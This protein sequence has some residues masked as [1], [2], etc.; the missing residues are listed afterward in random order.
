MTHVA[1]FPHTHTHTYKL[2]LQ[3]QLW[4]HLQYW[5]PQREKLILQWPFGERLLPDWAFSL[6]YC[7]S[8]IHC[9][10]TKQQSLYFLFRLA[11]A[12]PVNVNCHVT[13][14]NSPYF[15]NGAE[16]FCNLRSFLFCNAVLK[17]KC[18]IIFCL[19]CCDVRVRRTDGGSKSWLQGLLGVTV[20]C[21]NLIYC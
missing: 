12:Y 13:L 15:S 5:C 1:L 17:W 19:W 7:P 4:V 6:S 11:H 21:C 16:A 18:V 8:L 3:F 2:K 10:E 9:A 14:C 20:C